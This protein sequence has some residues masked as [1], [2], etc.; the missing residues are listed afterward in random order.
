[1]R[2]AT[3]L[4]AAMLRWRRRGIRRRAVEEFQRS[5]ALIVDPD[6]LRA[7]VSNRL[8]EIFDPDRLAIFELQPKL[9]QFRIALHSGFDQG[10]DP[11]TITLAE[12]GRMAR[13]FRVNGTCLRPAVESSVV[14]YF[15]IEER[16]LLQLC[17]AELCA[18]L[19][20]KNQLIGLFV[21][22]SEVRPRLFGRRDADLL[23]GLANQASLAFHNAALY[24]EQQDR[25]DRL[26]RSNRLAAM[27]QLAA[28]VA[29]EVRNPLTA[30]R[31]TVQY[32]SSNLEDAKAE[33]A[34]ELLDEV[35]RIDQIISNLLDL[36]R[37]GKLNR[38][39]IELLDVL[40]RTIRLI[41]IRAR[42]QGVEIEKSMPRPPLMLDADPDQLR[43]VFLNLILNGLQAMPEG[44]SLVISCAVD[45]AEDRV[46][47]TIAD[48]G[49]G[50]PA[51]L[52]EKV[53]DPFYTTKSEG[54]G[55]GLSVCHNIIVQHGGSIELSSSP[56]QGTRA[57]ILLP[58]QVDD[59]SR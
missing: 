15:T 43:Q 31:S 4:T 27:G 42:K 29:H 48:T 2:P 56:G 50:I 53:F 5:L 28:G 40:S 26:H 22:G 17:G 49:K 33:M 44:G 51:D 32:L 45:P 6:A 14:E 58:W 18:P 13:W 39:R 23:G 57:S 59:R 30:I 7:S 16:Q 41:E 11:A 19:V 12:G 38:H 10:V 52:I 54:T 37:S 46:G 36:T 47:I 1:M 3:A 21:L 9:G 24:R 8:K 35:D 34:Q 25:L 55:L 20:T